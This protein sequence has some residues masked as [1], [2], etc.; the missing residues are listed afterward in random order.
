MYWPPWQC[1]FW[2][3]PQLMRGADEW[4]N[5]SLLIGLPLVGALIVFYGRDFDRS[6]ELVVYP[7]PDPED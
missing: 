5:R 6:E 1:T 3:R 2:Y 7:L 4:D